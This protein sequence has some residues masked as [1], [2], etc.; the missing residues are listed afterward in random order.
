MKFNISFKKQPKE[1]GLRRIAS[2]YPHVDIKVNK[3]KCGNI[4]P[5]NWSSVDN[6]W[7]IQI[8]VKKP[9]PD[10]NPNCDWKWMM[11]KKDFDNEKEARQWCKDN[12]QSAVE[13][14]ELHYFED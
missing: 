5:P 1:T 4:S 7:R 12:L 6:N 14:Y 8:C 3:K 13:G 2:P 11:V 10:N 9:E